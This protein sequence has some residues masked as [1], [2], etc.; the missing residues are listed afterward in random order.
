MQD[1]R[2]ATFLTVCRTMNYTRAAEELNVT[3]PAVSQHIAY[4]EKAYGAS[5][6][7]YRNKKLALTAAGRMLR[8]ALSTMAHD[9]ALLRDRVAEAV[10]GSRVDLVVGMT[11][12]AGEYL[13]AA[14]LADFLVEHPRYRVTVRSGGT[15]E[16][17]ELLGMG[18][19]DCA[20]VEGFFDKS[21]YAWNVYRSERFVCVCAP[22]HHFSQDPGRVEDLFGEHVLVRERGSGTRAVLEHALAARNLSVDGFSQV[23][24]VESLDIIKVFV[25]RDMGIA[26]LYEAAVEREL[27]EGTLRA[28][29]LEGFSVEHDIAFI[30]LRNSIFEQEFQYLFDCL[31]GSGSR[32]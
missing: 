9:E 30:R 22:D 7:D 16:L 20:F 2:V 5:L 27:R 17:L 3:Q 1:F 13:V 14:P 21:A 11:L 28:V 23:S 12:T 15:A 19:I 25:Q 29:E 10:A 26:F 32:A 31:A 24:V 6:F 8:D 18:K 4:L